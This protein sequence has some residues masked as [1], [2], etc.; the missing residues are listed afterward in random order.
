MVQDNLYWNKEIDKVTEKFIEIS[1]SLTESQ[2]NYKPNPN[3]WSI[4]LEM[5]Q[6]LADSGT[7]K[8]SFDTN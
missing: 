4:N 6:G 1:G 2:F 3:T 5:S 8:W 7:K